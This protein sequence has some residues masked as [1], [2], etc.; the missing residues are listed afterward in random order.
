MSA[1]DQFPTPQAAYEFAQANASQFS[2]IIQSRLGASRVVFWPWWSD[3][4]AVYL[5]LEAAMRKAR[6][7]RGE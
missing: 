7:Q 5:G 1:L 6:A 2:E 4:G 3:E